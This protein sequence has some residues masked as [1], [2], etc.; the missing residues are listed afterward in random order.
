MSCF[1]PA[2]WPLESARVLFNSC[3]VS[4]FSRMSIPSLSAKERTMN[5]AKALVAF[6]WPLLAFAVV[7]FLSSTFRQVRPAL[8]TSKVNRA[9]QTRQDGWLFANTASS[10]DATVEIT[11]GPEVTPGKGAG[12]NLTAT[13]VTTYT[14][15]GTF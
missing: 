8:V 5:R 15:F 3:F 12:K 9:T 2:L 6:A 13:T 7:V 1:S 11:R 4:H 10:S 14:V